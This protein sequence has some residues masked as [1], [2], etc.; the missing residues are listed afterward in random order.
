MPTLA[1]LVDATCEDYNW[2]WKTNV[3]PMLLLRWV[4]L[5]WGAIAEKDLVALLIAAVEDGA[6]KVDEDD[7]FELVTN[8]GAPQFMRKGKRTSVKGGFTNPLVV[9]MALD[10]TSSG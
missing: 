1:D 6:G 4:T 8:N 3:T 10:S 7:A 9:I 2:K 5:D